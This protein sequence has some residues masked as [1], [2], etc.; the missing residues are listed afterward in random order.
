MCH[1]TLCG[2][3]LAPGGDIIVAHALPSPLFH[4]YGTPLISTVTGSS[5]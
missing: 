2:A 4:Q 3:E 5:A 1:P